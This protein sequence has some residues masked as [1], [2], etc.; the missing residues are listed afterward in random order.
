MLRYQGTHL[1]LDDVARAIIAET[2]VHTAYSLRVVR[3]RLRDH[4]SGK[5]RINGDRWLKVIEAANKK[6]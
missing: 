5:R 6:T 3:D 4:M 1:G 2:N